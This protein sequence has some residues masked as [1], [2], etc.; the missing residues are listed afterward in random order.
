MSNI[1]KLPKRLS[2]EFTHKDA[3]EI[4]EYCHNNEAHVSVA[5]IDVVMGGYEHWLARNNFQIIDLKE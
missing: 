5:D 1:K 3:L 2:K 4:Q